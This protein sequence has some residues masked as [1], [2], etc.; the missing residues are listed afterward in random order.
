[1]SISGLNGPECFTLLMRG[2][3]VFLRT[4]SLKNSL[5]E[6]LMWTEGEKESFILLLPVP[7]A[8]GAGNLFCCFAPRPASAQLLR[9][10]CLPL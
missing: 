7:S 3:P 8:L 10:P 2:N 1:M 4:L 9:A 6:S 5:W